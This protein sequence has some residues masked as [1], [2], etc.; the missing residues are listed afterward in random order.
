MQHADDGSPQLSTQSAEQGLVVDGVQ[1]VFPVVHSWVESQPHC[2]VCP[3]LSVM[4]TPQAPWQGLAGVQHSS[5]EVHTLPEPHDVGHC[6]CR[7]QL[8]VAKVLHLLLQAWA[9]CGEQQ[10]PSARHTSR[11]FVVQMERPRRPQLTFCPQLFEV[12]PHSRAPHAWSSGSASQPPPSQG[13]QSMSLLQLSFEGPQRCMHHAGSGT[14]L[15]APAS[16]QR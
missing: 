15:Q 8:S 6:T 3:Q 14:Q 2:T 13:P 16:V 9:L 5:F 7:P 4:L 1:H 11:T 12:E 10:P